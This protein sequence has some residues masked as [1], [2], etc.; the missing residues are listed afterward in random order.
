MGIGGHALLVFCYNFG[1]SSNSNEISHIFAYFTKT[2]V[3]ISSDSMTGVNFLFW[4]RL[5]AGVT[6]DFLD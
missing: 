5:L 6:L 1:H 3:T 2:V 4:L